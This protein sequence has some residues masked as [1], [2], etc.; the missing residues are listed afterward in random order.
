M[1]IRRIILLTGKELFHGSRGFMILAIVAPIVISLLFSLVFGTL[2]AGKPKLGIAD[3]GGS[4]IAALASGLPSVTV[5]T[6]PD[7]TALKR[8]VERGSVDIGIVVPE[9]FEEALRA[10]SRSAIQAFVWG[11]SLA[12]NRIIL[13][14]AI[15]GLV[16]ELSGGDAGANVETVM[17]GEQNSLPWSDRLLPMVVLVSVFIGGILL[18]ASSIIAE[19]EK[20]TLQ[21]LTVTPATAG[22]V[23]T[24][25]GLVG[26]IICFL[27]GMAIL[28][29]N[30]AFGASPGALVAIIALGA[31]M[32]VLIGLIL[33]ATLKDISTLFAAQKSG[34]IVLFAPAI[35]F[36]FPAIPQ[37]IGKL[38]PTYYL[39]APL[40]D[41]SLKGSKWADVFFPDI[42]VLIVIDAAL[43]ALL[44]VTLRLA[45]RKKEAV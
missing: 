40:M 22:E 28:A 31:V 23:F 33:G 32:A 39:L 17:L 25:K 30:R 3:R 45:S 4:R 35:I 38:F 29:L 15:A 9:G 2:F 43:A 20:K 36:L 13:G 14:A 41:V 10:G 19:K 27:M 6:Y 8:S 1:S 24:S 7:E 34:G 44:A 18:P 37:W 42:L 21:A 5:S 16:R 12:K 11:E 26:G